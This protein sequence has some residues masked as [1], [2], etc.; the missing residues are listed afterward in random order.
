ME[1][2]FNKKESQLDKKLEDADYEKQ[3]YNELKESVRRQE[4]MI[5]QEMEKYKARQLEL[6]T[7]LSRIGGM[8]KE[9]AKNLLLKEME[10]DAKVDFAKVARRLEEEAKEDAEKSA[11]NIIKPCHSAIFLVNT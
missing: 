1:K 5:A 11:K 9:E 4:T 6:S 8:T 2:D 7:E 3:K 10:E